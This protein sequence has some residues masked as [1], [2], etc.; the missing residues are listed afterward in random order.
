MRSK[1]KDEMLLPNERQITEINPA[2][3]ILKA[4]KDE[5]LKVNL[6]ERIALIDEMINKTSLEAERWVTISLLQKGIGVKTPEAAEE[7]MTGPTVFLRLLRSFKQSLV[8]LNQ[9]KRISLLK[10]PTQRANGQT[11][12]TVFP[13][14]R[15]DS[16]LFK[17]MSGEV[18]FEPGQTTTDVLNNQ[19]K[20]YHEAKQEGCISLILGAGNVS[21]LSFCDIFHK[22]FVEN[23]V[24]LFKINPILS[25]LLPVFN[26]VF[27]KLIQKGFL[28]ILEGGADLGAQLC[29]DPLISDIHL[30]GSYKT[31]QKIISSV[32][33]T[34]D[35]NISKTKTISAEL[36]NIT[37]VI[38][39]PGVWSEEELD[40]QAENL[41]SLMIANAGFN[42]ITPRILV[43]HSGW[44]QRTAFLNKI[45]N[46]LAQVPPRVAYYPGA[47]ETY[48][49]IKEGYPQVEQIGTCHSKD[50][51]P[52]LFVTDLLAEKE[53]VCFKEEI[54]CSF[55][56]E[57]C[58][59]AESTI[60]FLNKAVNFCNK[61]LWGT[62]AATLICDPVTLS[63][64]ATKQAVENAIE[65]LNYGRIDI[66]VG[67]G[68]GRYFANFPVGPYPPEN[69]FSV[70]SGIGFT[71][72]ALLLPD[73]EKILVRGPF[74]R[75]MKP[76]HFIT[77]K[78]KL[79]LAILMTQYEA[80]PGFFNFLKL[81]IAVVLSKPK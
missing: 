30:T 4:A 55:Y 11:L 67:G 7:W 78:N 61:R 22:L 47:M 20:I 24:V 59:P 21:S 72:N 45:R 18:W 70:Q 77:Q 53:E 33:N 74:Y 14:N 5:W 10:P 80:K 16:I 34:D 44:A 65:E 62:L 39:V 35:K 29:N 48:K 26:T 81:L 46:L 42:C 40:Y 71:A 51:L 54:F 49:K 23:K 50:Q 63:A 69:I 8:E 25:A 58:I 36:G 32:F 13:K 15:V 73:P 1:E 19:A 79:N 41:V 2:L 60:E 68:M 12:I 76:V 43:T 66:N 6:I 56:A 37:P 28:Q 17:E 38:I 52:W 9:Q 3:H 64:P 75:K 57:V 27:E 31:Y